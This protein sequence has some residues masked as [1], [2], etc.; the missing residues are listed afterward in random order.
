[1]TEKKMHKD[2]SKD[3]EKCKHPE[4]KDQIYGTK[5]CGDC[6]SSRGPDGKWRS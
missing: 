6:N 5:H 2:A 3:P 4:A 1:M